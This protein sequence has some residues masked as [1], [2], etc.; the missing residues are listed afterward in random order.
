MLRLRT[1]TEDWREL[2]TGAIDE[3]EARHGCESDIDFYDAA[4]DELCDLVLTDLF[5]SDVM[6][7]RAHQ[8][9]VGSFVIVQNGTTVER[10][11]F[12]AAVEKHLPEAIATVER[13]AASAAATV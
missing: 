4:A 6:W 12:D 5:D 3:A 9:S 11:A 2:L 1:N 10:A 13:L 7:E 8:Q